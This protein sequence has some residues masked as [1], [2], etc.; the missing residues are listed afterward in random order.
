MHLEVLFSDVFEPIRELVANR[1]LDGAGNANAGRF[2]QCRK[3]HGY[4]AALAVDLGAGFD[5]RRESVPRQ[6]S[7]GTNYQIVAVTGDM[8]IGDPNA[9]SNPPLG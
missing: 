7:D 6:C 9:E 2:G 4:V 5:Q 1:V 8:T 3:A